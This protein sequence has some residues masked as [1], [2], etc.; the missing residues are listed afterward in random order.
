M[1]S[2]GF[3]HYRDASSSSLTT[4]SGSSL[5]S[6]TGG[7]HMNVPM[8][9]LTPIPVMITSPDGSL[10]RESMQSGQ[11]EM[12]PPIF[13]THNE[14][15]I[16]P[17][18]PFSYNS[19]LSSN[20]ERKS[21]S[22]LSQYLEKGTLYVSWFPQFLDNE[23]SSSCPQD[24]SGNQEDYDRV[25]EDINATLRKSRGPS[26]EAR[27]MH[28]EPSKTTLDSRK[29]ECRDAIRRSNSRLTMDQI[30]IN[31]PPR[32]PSRQHLEARY[33]PYMI[34]PRKGNLWKTSSRCAR[35]AGTIV[36]R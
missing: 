7:L 11:T 34:S 1:S 24:D 31:T 5:A 9:S 19:R 36:I 8:T 3:A 6:S 16:P 30:P 14:V 13:Y 35:S 18:S 2:T 27:R 15:I 12:K 21:L 28:K 23:H 25:L 17:S 22:I 29:S 33:S 10:R 4:G 32:S 26:Q 20:F